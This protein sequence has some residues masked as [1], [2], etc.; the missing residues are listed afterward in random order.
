M[1]VVLRAATMVVGVGLSAVAIWLIVTA[2]TPKAWRIGALIGLWGLLLSMYSMYG[3]RRHDADVAGVAAGGELMVRGL[4]GIDTL[5]DAAAV[6]AYEQRL[7]EMLRSE[8]QQTLGAELASLRSEVAALRSE[9]VEKV[10][11]QLRLERIETT[12]VIGS[13]I[14]A[15]QHEVQQLKSGRLGDDFVGSFGRS[16]A[17]AV[18]ARPGRGTVDAHTV[19]AEIVEA[20]STRE[21]QRTDA[22][23]SFTVT[24]SVVL[25]HESAPA[26]HASV[27]V[28]PTAVQPAPSEYTPTETI[29]RV[30]PL[31]EPSAAQPPAPT[32]TRRPPSPAPVASHSPQPALAPEP[33]PEPV[34]SYSPPVVA[35]PEPTPSATYDPFASLPRIRPFTEFDLDPIEGSAAPVSSEAPSARHSGGDQPV[36]A[37]REGGR[38]RREDN[39]GDD[40]LGRILQRER[41]TH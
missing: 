34:A 37:S 18:R 33:Q 41:Q 38:R 28:E 16:D 32:P 21:A 25:T 31:T 4:T 2:D 17:P 7:K 22:G 24:E 12:R 8:I 1:G 26:A 30:P 15:L 39:E 23:S 11:G 9:V 20:G 6:R 5:S 35:E 29:Q 14:E 19:E 3:A 27:P 36:A 10:G 13:D 40:I